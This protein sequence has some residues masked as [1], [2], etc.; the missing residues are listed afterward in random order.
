MN[1]NDMMPEDA[2][3]IIA[4]N[5]NMPEAEKRRLRELAQKNAEKKKRGW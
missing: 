1:E 3:R 2:E 4:A 5:H